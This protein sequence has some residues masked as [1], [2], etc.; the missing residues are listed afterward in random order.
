ML[1]EITG[2]NSHYGP[3]QVIHGISLSVHAGELVALVGGNG[4][5]KTTLLHTLSS[6]HPPSAGTI[7]FDGHDITRWPSHRIVAAGIC[8][9]PEGRQVFAPLSV[10]DNL[11]LGAYRQHR[12]TGWIRHEM[13]RVYHL[14]PILHERRQQLAGT[15]SGGQQ[16]MLAIGRAL[17]GRPR[18]L[19]L[20]EPSMGLAP[21]L[22]EEIFRVIVELNTQGVTILL[23]EQNARAALAIAGRGYILETGRIVKTA[24]ASEL[25]A[26]DDVRRAYLGY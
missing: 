23:V 20:D 2:L 22:V 12:N 11:R 18:L 25:L 16:Q 13:E 24:P 8:Q 7:R 6:L 19:L 5:G 9:V 17:L 4:A 3:V 14:F 15:L 21:L 26:D 1:L 10:E